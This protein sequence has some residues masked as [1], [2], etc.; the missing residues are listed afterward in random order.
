MLRV[1]TNSNEQSKSKAYSHMLI[2][3]IV[4]VIYFVTIIVLVVLYNIYCATF[5]SLESLHNATTCAEYV[6]GISFLF[7]GMCF[8]YYGICTLSILKTKML[9]FY[10]KYFCLLFTVSFGISISLTLR[11]VLIIVTEQYP[12]A[13]HF[14]NENMGAFTLIGFLL[15]NVIPLIF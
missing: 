8:A 10:K 4:T 9:E 7:F 14:T 2:N 12:K 6:N 3:T 11:G 13:Q 1:A 5:S 15:E